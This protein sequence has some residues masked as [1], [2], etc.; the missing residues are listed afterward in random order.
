MLLAFFLGSFGAHR[1]YAG[2]PGSAIAMLLL[3]CSVFG[4]LVSGIWAVVD[5]WVTA[6]GSFRDGRG[7]LILDW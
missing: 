6:F 5:T 2:R 7:N 1:F 4:L 3:T